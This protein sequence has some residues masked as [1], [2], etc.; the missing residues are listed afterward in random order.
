MLASLFWAG[1]QQEHAVED[2]QETSADVGEDSRPEKRVTCESQRDDRCLGHHGH[3]NILDDLC[4][5][6]LSQLNGGGNLSNVVGHE[7]HVARLHCDGGARDSHG[8]AD[9]CRSQRGSVVYP[10][11]DHDRGSHFTLEVPH[12]GN[13]VFRQQLGVDHVELLPHLQEEVF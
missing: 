6:F 12:S 3:D 8:D 13:F 11:S 1:F 7:R 4:L 10:I 2:A 9:V 5:R